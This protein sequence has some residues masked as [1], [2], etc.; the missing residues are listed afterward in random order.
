MI[1]V[2][3]SDQERHLR[4]VIPEWLTR[5]PEHEVLRR[6]RLAD[7]AREDARIES[8]ARRRLAETVRSVVLFTTIVQL[9][10]TGFALLP[11]LAALGLGLVL[12][13]LVHRLDEGIFVWIVRPAG[14]L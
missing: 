13:P 1:E 10:L 2:P 8:H 3:R 12:G 7:E 14:V 6:Q 9:A 5:P 4:A 11:M